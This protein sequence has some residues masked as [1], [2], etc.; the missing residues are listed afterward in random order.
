MQTV[1]TLTVRGASASYSPPSAFVSDPSLPHVDPLGAAQVRRERRLS[2]M[3]CSLEIGHGLRSAW[4]RCDIGHFQPWPCSLSL[5]APLHSSLTVLLSS[6]CL[7]LR[8]GQLPPSRGAG[9]ICFLWLVWLHMLCQIN[10]TPGNLSFNHLPFRLF[11]SPHH[12]REN[13]MTFVFTLISAFDLIS[14]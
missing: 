5:A 11:F 6:L 14:F 1:L 9:D 4:P 10:T 8:A 3:K 7:L 2:R 12:R 13:Q